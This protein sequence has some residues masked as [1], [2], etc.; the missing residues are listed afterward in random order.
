MM[1]NWKSSIISKKGKS[2]Q[3]KGKD[4]GASCQITTVGGVKK[5]YFAKRNRSYKHPSYNE[6]V[7]HVNQLN[8][9]K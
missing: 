1:G 8:G 7:N 9:I 5:S 6:W 2:S 3:T 4:K